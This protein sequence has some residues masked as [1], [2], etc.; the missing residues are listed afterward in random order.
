MFRET[1]NKKSTQIG[2]FFVEG[3]RGLGREFLSL[4]GVHGDG[5]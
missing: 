2:Q 3:G 1:G 4:L 5:K